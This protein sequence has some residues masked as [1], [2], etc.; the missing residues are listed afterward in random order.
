MKKIYL[1]SIIILVLGISS[2]IGYFIIRD[3]TATIPEGT[4]LVTMNN[5]VYDFS[6][7]EKKLK[8]LEFLYT[9]CPD[10]CPTTTNKMNMLKRDLEKEGVFGKN[11]QF[12]T[13]SI[14]P[15]RDTPEV[16]KRYMDTFDIE[17]DGN[18][19]LLTG[20]HDNLKQDQAEIRELAN[21]FQFQYRDPGDGFYVHSTFVYLLSEDNKYLK[22]FPM[23]EEFDK[24][25]AFANI[26][27][28]I[29]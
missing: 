19:L 8:V 15:Y 2:G 6:K 18:W 7:S 29:D 21:T 11:V 3:K 25:D 16:L 10:I 4:T 9:H 14:D 5:E 23:G 26:M 24:D 27:K 1:T 13:V 17:D 22:K 28:E 20:D 12:I